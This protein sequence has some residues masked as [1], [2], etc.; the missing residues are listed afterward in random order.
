MIVR[1]RRKSSRPAWR[2]L[3]PDRAKA[4]SRNT[5]LEIDP[6]QLEDNK[7]AFREE[8]ETSIRVKLGVLTLY[9][10]SLKDNTA[11]IR[12]LETC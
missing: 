8:I 6:A 12:I 4:V 9:A 11:N 2:L 3:K 5:E 7:A 10:V 1:F